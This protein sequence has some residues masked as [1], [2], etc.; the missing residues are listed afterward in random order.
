MRKN[1][2]SIGAPLAAG[3]VERRYSGIH[4]VY[5]PIHMARM[6]AMKPLHHGN[7][8]TICTRYMCQKTHAKYRHHGDIMD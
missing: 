5:E 4:S 7:T 8:K 2:C 3:F 1:G 6:Q